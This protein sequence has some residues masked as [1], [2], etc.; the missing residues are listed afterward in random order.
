MSR[1]EP[2]AASAR[3]RRGPVLRLL[4]ANAGGALAWAAQFAVG[5]GLAGYAC[6]PGPVIRETP[7]DGWLWTRG[8]L[9]G[10][11]L[12][13]LAVALL[14]LLT[15]WREWRVHRSDPGRAHASELGEDWDGF[16]ALSGLMI[17]AAMVA[18]VLFTTIAI[19]GTPRCNG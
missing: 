6:S 7:L 9:F 1:K 2:T 3:P 19:V 13:A 10:L 15:G 11:N 14:A 18:A 17:G 4:F 16:L 5:Y 12:V 8:P